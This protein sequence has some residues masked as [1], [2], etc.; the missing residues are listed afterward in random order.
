MQIQVYFYV[1]LMFQVASTRDLIL[2]LTGLTRDGRD[3]DIRRLDG[4][5]LILGQQR[6]V[7]NVAGHDRRHKARQ[8]GQL[9]FRVAIEHLQVGINFNIGINQPDLKIVGNSPMFSL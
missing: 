4:A 9:H 6:V 7:A 3:P 2:V 5:V 8:L 1:F